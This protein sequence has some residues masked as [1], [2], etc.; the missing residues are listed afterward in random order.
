MR[1]S[2]LTLAVVAVAVATFAQPAPKDNRPDLEIKP[3][4]A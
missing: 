3:A 1:H 4:W 2:L